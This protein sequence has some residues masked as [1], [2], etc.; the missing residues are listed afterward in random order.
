M[1][2][3]TPTCCLAVDIGASSGRVILGT[4]SG[5]KITMREVHRFVNEPAM[6]G[7]TL[8]WRFTTLREEVLRGL[9]LGAQAAKADGLSIA[10][11]GVDT[12]G[13]DYGLLDQ[14]GALLE[15]PV[16]YR[17]ARTN[18]LMEV[19]FRELVPADTIFHR[20]G[21]Q[22]MQFNTLFQLVA[23]SRSGSEKL[24]AAT[25]L[26]LMG[27]LFH[28]SLAGTRSVEFTN[29]T[30]TQLCD[31]RTR[32][33]A[34][35]LIDH[36]RLPRHLFPPLV[37]PG[38][39]LGPLLPE[40]AAATG[41]ADAQLIA[42][43]THDTA[44][45]VA[46]VPADR[47]RFAY[48]SC[49]TWSLIGTEVREPVL[50]ENARAL[51]FTNEGGVFGTFRLLKNV[52]GLWLLQECQRQWE[53]EGQRL[54]WDD[55]VK[56]AATAPPLASLINP[57]DS[58]FFPPGDMVDRIRR[59]CVEQG[60]Q[61]PTTPGAITRCILESL[62]LA[63]RRRLRSVESLIGERLPVLHIVGGGARNALLCQFTADACGIPV[64][65]G[66]VEATAQGN[67][68][69][70]FAAAGKI[71]TLAELR[72]VIARSELPTVYRPQRGINWDAAEA[73]VPG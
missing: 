53:R 33:W 1:P 26:L 2:T 23:E 47:E 3:S 61:E 70:Q 50:T 59:R 51:N 48:I 31:P 44:S 17:D 62:A 29:A 35:D 25:Q 8:R 65:A 18:D 11:V 21:I 64:H 39:R 46:A 19:V 34:W 20:T 60:E 32:G 69:M 67:M 13:V 28:Q 38:T 54:T 12:W 36:L 73:R 58:L 45:A 49:G 5:G 56:Q 27:D 52:M 10:T 42:V 41:L 7:T 14:S 40:V 57:D 16:H 43:G 6:D 9:T 72:G 66:P 30:T 68:G 22:F 55:L 24:T 63:Y 4:L 37:E 71:G 15:Q